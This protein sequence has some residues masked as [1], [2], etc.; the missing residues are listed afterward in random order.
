M[1]AAGARRQREQV[2]CA[3][4]LR[5]VERG[6]RGVGGGLLDD[7]RL[8]ARGWAEVWTAHMKSVTCECGDST[9]WRLLRLRL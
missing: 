8:R 9:I 3:V 1:Q 4:I 7:G 2:A 6:G 5:D